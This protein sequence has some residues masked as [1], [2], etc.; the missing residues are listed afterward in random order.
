MLGSGIL[1]SDSKYSLDKAYSDEIK[2]YL[3]SLVEVTQSIEEITQKGQS[4]FGVLA[5]TIVEQSPNLN[6][7]DMPGVT[8]FIGQALTDS[9]SEAG[10]V[11]TAFKNNIDFEAEKK[12]YVEGLTDEEAKIFNDATSEVQQ[13]IL[14]AQKIA[15]GDIKF[16]K[17]INTSDNLE[18]YTKPG[19]LTDSAISEKINAIG[20]TED[21]LNV[22]TELL[23]VKYNLTAANKEEE[24]SLKALAVR[25]LTLNKGLE[26]LSST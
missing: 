1:N 14:F 18:T 25:Q 24:L 9:N 8:Q 2:S 11:F 23:K 21:E 16:T 12:D 6:E 7:S 22:Y 20:V 17:T 4:E 3:Q 10:K 15:D 13:Q 5:S 26:N 19:N